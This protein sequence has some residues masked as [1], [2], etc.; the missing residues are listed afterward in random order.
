[1]IE[2]T[3]TAKGRTTVPEAVHQV[4]SLQAGAV[5]PTSPG[6]GQVCLF[7][8]RPINRLYGVLRHHGPVATLDDL[9]D[10]IAKGAVGAYSRSTGR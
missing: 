2:P 5:S 10:S 1:M 8:V 4:L 7:G 6:D 3:A 9:E